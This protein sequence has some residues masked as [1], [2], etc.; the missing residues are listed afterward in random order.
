MTETDP[1]VD[2]EVKL[3]SE[4]ED[5]T[6]V[7]KEIRGIYQKYREMAS[8]TFSTTVTFPTTRGLVTV[9]VKRAVADNMLSMYFGFSKEDGKFQPIRSIRSPVISDWVG[10]VAEQG[11]TS[12]TEKYGWTP[13]VYKSI[14]GAANSPEMHSDGYCWVSWSETEYDTELFHF[15]GLID[16]AR[17]SRI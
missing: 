9:T 14:S 2:L 13:A 8:R 1:F 12:E 17:I 15:Y 6:K 5:A 10:K 16:T 7:A 4:R 11:M 3:K